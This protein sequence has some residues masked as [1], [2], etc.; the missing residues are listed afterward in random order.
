MSKKKERNVNKRLSKLVYDGRKFL[1]KS[2][3]KV[4]VYDQYGGRT[5]D[6][7]VIN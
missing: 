3:K 2:P 5:R 1:L 6:L 4:L 7:G